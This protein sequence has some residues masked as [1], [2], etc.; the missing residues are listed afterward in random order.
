MFRARIHTDFLLKG[1][2]TSL[3]LESRVGNSRWPSAS[4]HCLLDLDAQMLTGLEVAAGFLDLG[5]LG[6]QG[7]SLASWAQNPDIGVGKAC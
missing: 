7:L 1:N 6:D 4:L 5:C 3:G 2:K